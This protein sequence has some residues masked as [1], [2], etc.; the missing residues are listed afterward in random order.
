M[1]AFE[2]LT[3]TEVQNPN[4]QRLDEVAFIPIILWAVSAASLAYGGLEIYS[5]FKQTAG[6]DSWQGMVDYWKYDA[7]DQDKEDVAWAIAMAAAGVVFPAVRTTRAIRALR[8]M[9][10]RSGRIRDA[11][12]RTDKLRKE[13]DDAIAKETEV[14]GAP[15]GETP[16]PSR[17]GPRQEPTMRDPRQAEAAKQEWLSVTPEKVGAT[18]KYRVEGDRVIDIRTGR[19]VEVETGILGPGGQAVRR[20]ARPDEIDTFNISP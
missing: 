10:S 15:R 12:R 14:R 8:R 11:E 5:A 6:R 18:P 9:L 3:E 4:A 16:P 7:T 13:L 20:A 17:G 2:F 19:P 1:R